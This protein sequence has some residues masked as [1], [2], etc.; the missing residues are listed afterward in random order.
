MY[1]FKIFTSFG[2]QCWNEPSD[3]NPVRATSQPTGLAL[4]IT[5]V[6]IAD[7]NFTVSNQLGII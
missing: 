5:D 6:I 2:Q 7:A 4:P 1:T 3:T